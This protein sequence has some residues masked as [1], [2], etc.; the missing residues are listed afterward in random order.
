MGRGHLIALEG[1]DQA[2]KLT[3]SRMLASRLRREG[4]SV[5][6]LSFPDY[7][8]PIGRK[9]RSYLAGDV[10]CPEAIHMLYSANRW[11]RA[12]AI[13]SLVRQGRV[14]IVDRYI[15]SN[16]AYGHARGL[17]LD[18]LLNL[19]RG[20]P[21]PSAVV[22]IDVRPRTSL[23]RKRTRRDIHERDLT[24]LEKVRRNYLRLSRRFGWRVVRGE[25]PTE[26]VLEE[27]HRYVRSVL[28][29]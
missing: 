22:V 1:I 15:P 16:L 3:Q 25:R 13:F 24:F 27:I 17:A 18:W 7:S 10:S 23:M 9:I 26:D 5:S 21:K 14:V 29:S 2:G 12:E 8:S 28:Q 19:D 4:Y 11:E 6:V 20:L